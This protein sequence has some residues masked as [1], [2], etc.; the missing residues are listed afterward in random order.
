M[1]PWTDPRTLEVRAAVLAPLAGWIGREWGTGPAR[2]LDIGCGDLLLARLLPGCR[3]DGFDI[4]GQAREA[5]R[6]TSA[7]VERPGEVFERRGRIPEGAYDGVVMSSMLQYLPDHAAVHELVRDVARWLVPRGARGAVVTDVVTPDGTRVADALDMGRF[8]V[9]T[10][11]PVRAP[12][13]VLRSARRSPGR[14]L[15]VPERV[16]T[17]AATGAGLQ[18]RRCTQNLSP[19]AH[20]ASYVLYPT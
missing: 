6:R 16:V 2:L 5:A 10:V 9:R 3:V 19:L 14:L 11:G 4:S 18:A 15:V 17:E 13:L 12:R 8:L 20:R 7:S 1:D